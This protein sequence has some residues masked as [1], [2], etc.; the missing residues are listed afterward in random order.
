MRFLGIFPLKV[1]IYLDKTPRYLPRRCGWS[2]LWR[3]EPGAFPV[4]SKQRHVER[5][6][7]AVY[8]SV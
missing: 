3:W 5:V 2:A 7:L 1:K 8:C 4:K 6:S